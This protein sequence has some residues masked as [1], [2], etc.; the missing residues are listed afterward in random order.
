LGK[1]S[2]HDLGLL[3][4][5]SMTQKTGEYPTQYLHNKPTLRETLA[6]FIQSTCFGQ[7]FVIYLFFFHGTTALSRPE[8][9]HCRGFTITL[10]HTTFRGTPLDEWSARHRDLYLITH[11]PHRRHTSMSPAEFEPATPES[12]RPQT[13]ASHRAAT[14]IAPPF[15]S[16]VI[17][18]FIPFFIIFYQPEPHRPTTMLKSRC[19]LTYSL[20]YTIA[21]AQCKTFVKLPWRK[22]NFQL[23]TCQVNGISFSLIKTHSIA[24]L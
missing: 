23:E 22:Q 16:T 17:K 1:L 20:L 9:S 2:A 18:I 21:N 10:R 3:C 24:W 12:E 13:H 14:G 7:N 8:P 15:P 19:F 5:S 4:H 11:D 6:C